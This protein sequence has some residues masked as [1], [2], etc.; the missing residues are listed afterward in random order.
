MYKFLPLFLLLFVVPSNAQDKLKGSRNVKTEQYD[1]STFHSIKVSGELEVGILKGNQPM[2]EIEADDNLHDY[3]LTE[4]LDGVLVIKPVKEFQ[5]AKRQELRIT[6]TDSLK[7]IT[8]ED[9]VEISGLQDI[10]SGDLSLQVKD[11]AR[12]Y[13]T[14]KARV[15]SLTQHDDSKSELNINSE[16]ARFQINKSSQ[17]EA[18]VNS[19]AFEIDLYEKGSASIEGEIQELQVR[20]DQSSKFDGENLSSSQAEVLAQ[21][22][23]ELKINVTETLRI[24]ATGDSEIEIYNE[25]KIEILEFKGEASISKKE[26]SSGLFK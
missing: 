24:H 8:A 1:L 3:I 17:V 4:V 7:S 22:D 18:L 26:F 21:G 9:E 10:Y 12:A 23:C 11:K 6:F 19:P 20:A 13:F 15:F 14:I 2:V 16:K 5:K 25:P